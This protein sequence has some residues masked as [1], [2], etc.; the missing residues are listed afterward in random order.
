MFLIGVVYYYF[1]LT[2]KLEV[3]TTPSTV[4]AI[5]SHLPGLQTP[6]SGRTVYPETLLRGYDLPQPKIETVKPMFDPL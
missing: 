2:L 1:C 4:A 3:T 5:L 6:N